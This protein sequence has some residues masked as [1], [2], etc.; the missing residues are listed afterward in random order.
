MKNFSVHNPMLKNPSCPTMECG[1]FITAAENEVFAVLEAEKVWKAEGYT[2]HPE[3]SV[4]R[5]IGSE[6]LFNF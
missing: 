3:M 6:P 1:N 4:A 5:E 2:F